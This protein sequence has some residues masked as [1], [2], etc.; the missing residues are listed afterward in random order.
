MIAE[1]KNPST[2]I[3][4]V[5]HFDGETPRRYVESIKWAGGAFCAKCGSVNVGVIFSLKVDPERG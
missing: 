1:P 3:E 2:L 4:A 5:R